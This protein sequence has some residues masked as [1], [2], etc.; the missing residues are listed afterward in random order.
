MAGFGAH[1]LDGAALADDRTLMAVAGQSRLLSL[2]LLHGTATAR[3]TAPPGTFFSGPP[4]T[5]GSATYVLRI[6]PTIE[7]IVGVDERGTEV[8]R[9]MLASHPAA[10]STDAG[11]GPLVLPPHTPPLV[12][13]H[14]TVAFATTASGTP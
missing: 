2:D 1:I 3:A 11:A 13:D 12:D 9:T 8:F 14:G 10:V 4:A 7:E 6:A 5:G